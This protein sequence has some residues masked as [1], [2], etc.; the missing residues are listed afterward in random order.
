MLSVDQARFL[1]VCLFVKLFNV[2]ISVTMSLL[3]ETSLN[4]QKMKITMKIQIKPSETR[5][6]KINPLKTFFIP[7]ITNFHN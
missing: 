5:Y 3:G 4:R 7:K 1:F 6:E 2:G